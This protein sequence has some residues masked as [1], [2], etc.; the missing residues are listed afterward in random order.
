MHSLSYLL[1]VA[2]VA[3]VLVHCSLRYTRL[4]TFLYTRVPLRSRESRHFC[5]LRSLR[6]VGTGREKP[7]NLRG[8]K[9]G[10]PALAYRLK[11]DI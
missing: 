10:G 7:E 3:F 2:L 8:L 6:V 9:L 11:E 1:A 4:D 5:N